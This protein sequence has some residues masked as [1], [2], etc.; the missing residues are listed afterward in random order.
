[1]IKNPRIRLLLGIVLGGFAGVSLCVS[2]LPLVLQMIG[3]GDQTALAYQLAPYIPHAA[4]V[5]AVG[6]WAVARTGITVAGATILSIVGL[7]SGTLLA[8]FGL[9]SEARLLGG[10]AFGG[11]FYGFLGGLILGRILEVP[12]PDDAEE[13]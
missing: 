3:A 5:W 11:A 9:G 13:T 2:I 10:G 4:L 6:G 8:Y 7:V 12:P 1:M